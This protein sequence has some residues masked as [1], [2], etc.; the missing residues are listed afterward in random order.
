LLILLSIINT[1]TTFV[2]KNTNDSANAVT[3]RSPSYPLHPV[4]NIYRGDLIAIDYI[5]LHWVDGDHISRWTDCKY[6]NDFDGNDEVPTGYT[7]PWWAAGYH[8]E[9]YDEFYGQYYKTDDVMWYNDY[10][11]QKFCNDLHFHIKGFHLKLS[12]SQTT[13]NANDKCYWE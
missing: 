11:D 7:S 3:E 4:D 9:A 5:C 13:I 12:Y 10:Q 1:S 2:I 6:S 8:F